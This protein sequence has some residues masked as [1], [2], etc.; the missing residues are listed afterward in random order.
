MNLP[1]WV[2]STLPR[3]PGPLARLIRAILSIGS[4]RPPV[5]PGYDERQPPAE[6]AGLPAQPKGPAP[7]LR[8]GVALE[9]PQDSE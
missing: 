4:R 2:E 5:V 9:L 3:E 6:G 7:T 1:E 8:A